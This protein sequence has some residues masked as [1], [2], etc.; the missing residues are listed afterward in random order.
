MGVRDSCGFV[1][2][3]YDEQR[4]RQQQWLKQPPSKQVEAFPTS[5]P[6]LTENFRE[7]TFTVKVK[8]DVDDQVSDIR[9][10]CSSVG[11]K[12]DSRLSE[13]Y[14]YHQKT[15]QGIS[16]HTY[17][18]SKI[19]SF[20]CEVHPS[21]STSEN[22]TYGTLG[23]LAARASLRNITLS[24]EDGGGSMPLIRITR[25]FR[26]LSESFTSRCITESGS[27][28]DP[29]DTGAEGIASPSFEEL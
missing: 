5:L 18:C 24:K 10:I 29:E 13:S 23:V 21:A 2:E 25:G 14:R 9:K 4:V 15:E 11:S 3:S 22:N 28:A 8:V 26:I 6:L 17:D 27:Q 1:I 19:Y 20:W 16:Y 12:I 7:E